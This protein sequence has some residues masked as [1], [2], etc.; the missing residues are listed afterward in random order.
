[1][2]LGPRSFYLLCLK[3]TLCVDWNYFL[4]RL[5]G[6]WDLIQQSKQSESYEVS[7]ST[8][9]RLLKAVSPTCKCDPWCWGCCA[10]TAQ[11]QVNSSGSVV[12]C[13]NGS[14][15]PLFVRAAVHSTWTNAYAVFQENLICEHRNLSFIEFA[16]HEVAFISSPEI[17]PIE[18]GSVP[19]HLTAVCMCK[20]KGCYC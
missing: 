2:L 20:G 17:W 9:R 19:S 8:Q 6:R 1:M 7:G 15:L 11:S 3:I 10:V 18:V 5:Y 14:V 12:S 16:C 13:Q 4:P